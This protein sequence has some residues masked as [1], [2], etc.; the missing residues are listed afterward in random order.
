M[1]PRAHNILFNMTGDPVNEMID[2]VHT[3]AHPKDS[4]GST[5]TAISA[6]V[7]E[8]PFALFAPLLHFPWEMLQAPLWVDMANLSH[9]EEVRA[10]T[11]GAFGDVVIALAAYW[12]GS[13]AAPSRLWLLDPPRAAS[14]TY[15]LVGLVRTIAYEFAATGPLAFWEYAPSQPR[16][17]VLGTGLA[18][19]RFSVAPA[20]SDH[21]L[22]Y[23][24]PCAGTYQ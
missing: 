9:A 10:C 15:L 8:L 20:A 18:R 11:I 1:Y 2:R 7:P 6:R 14:I 24:H 21:P 19:P 4:G 13:L 3:P 23:T 17:P 5:V 22:A 12:S 16:L